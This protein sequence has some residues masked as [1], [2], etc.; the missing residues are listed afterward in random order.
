MKRHKILLILTVFFPVITDAAIDNRYLPL[1]APSYQ[2]Q[3]SKRS[4]LFSNLFITTA[5]EGYV[6]LK[7][8]VALPEIFGKYDL[9]KTAKALEKVGKTNPL[10]TAWL[11]PTTLVWDMSGKLHGQGVWIG[12]EQYITHDISFGAKVPFM[13]LST[14][15]EFATNS[16]LKK[17]LGLGAGGEAALYKNLN[18]VN[19]ALGLDSYQWKQTGFGD[20]DIYLRWGTV[21]DYAFKCKHVDASFKVGG[22]IPVGDKSDINSPMS[23]PFGGYNHYGFYF[24]ADF[25]CELKDDWKAGFWLN[26]TK[27]ISRTQKRRMSAGDELP[28]FGAVTGDA[29]VDPGITVGFSPY[30]L[31]DDLREGLGVRGSFTLISH[32]QD[33]WR[34]KR[35]DS[36]VPV[37]LAEVIKV[38]EWNSEHFTAGVVY[39]MQQTSKYREYAPY[40]YANWD[41]PTKIFDSNRIS[42][43]HRLT[44]GLE[45]NF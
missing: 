18:A 17:D 14:Q 13:H 15:L 41:I 44:F 32:A 1:F 42:K 34:D 23:I 38:S 19:K 30:F 10:P 8:D 45:F 39:D 9:N 33:F 28:Q 11:L 20:L 5:D 35:E 22:L 24:A 29:F 7:G 21:Q 2:H 3:E 40:I 37:K 4:V 43:T 36:S 27:R 12:Y 25:N 26:A 16:T 6:D 31:L